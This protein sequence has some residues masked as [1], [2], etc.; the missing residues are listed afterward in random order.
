MGIESY[1]SYG[2]TKFS[3]KRKTMNKKLIA[4]IIFLASLFLILAEIK[5]IK[6]MYSMSVYKKR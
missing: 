1:R 2:M 6:L 3:R 4:A 5:K